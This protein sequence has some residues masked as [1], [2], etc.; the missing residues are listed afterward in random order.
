MHTDGRLVANIEFEPNAVVFYERP[1]AFFPLTTVLCGYCHRLV[2][3]CNYPC[4]ACNKIL[5]CDDVCHE[6]ARQ[7]SHG[8][9]CQYMPRLLR[10]VP[11]LVYQI[12]A[13]ADLEHLVSMYDFDNEKAFQASIGSQFCD[14][15]FYLMLYR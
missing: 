14:M 5:F 4:H 3:M 10:G 7:G 1:V 13:N 2:K 6:L 9:T 11:L 8:K 15:I 12:L